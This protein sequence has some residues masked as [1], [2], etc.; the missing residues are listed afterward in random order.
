M[1]TA[2]LYVYIFEAFIAH[3][4]VNS[5][6]HL[7]HTSVK[8]KQHLLSEMLNGNDVVSLLFNSKSMKFTQITQ[9]C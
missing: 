8:L 7:L 2:V 1:W 5:L 6:S 3:K 4:L 9:N